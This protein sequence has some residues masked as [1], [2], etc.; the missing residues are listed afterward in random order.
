MSLSQKCQYAVRAVL[1]LSR[2]RNGGPVPAGEIA[3]KQAVPQRFLEVI[4]NE[5]RPTGLIGSRRGVRGGYYLSREPSQVTVGDVIRLVEGPMDPVR[6]TRGNRT[7]CPV[8][9]NCALVELWERAKRAVED[10]YD[11]TSFQDLVDRE[12]VLADVVVPD[13]CI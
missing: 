5:L 7:D 2:N 11:S 10:V 3:A 13:Y 8:Q 12:N 6:C 1:E 4:L 9:H